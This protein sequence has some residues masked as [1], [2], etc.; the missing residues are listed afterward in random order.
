VQ[1]RQRDAEHSDGDT[2]LSGHAHV[3]PVCGLRVFRCVL[4]ETVESGG[5]VKWRATIMACAFK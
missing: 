5:V 4:V 1:R 3:S 2:G